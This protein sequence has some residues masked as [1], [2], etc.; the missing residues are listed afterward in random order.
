M[1][2]HI[3]SRHQEL[4]GMQEAVELMREVPPGSNPLDSYYDRIGCELRALDPTSTDHGTVCRYVH[5]THG[6]THTRYRLAVLGVLTVDRKEEAKAFAKYKGVRAA[7]CVMRC[8]LCAAAS[9]D[10]VGG[11]CV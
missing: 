10:R 5:N 1:L 6:P 11:G 8:V 9:G 3:P 2:T 7:C 4:R